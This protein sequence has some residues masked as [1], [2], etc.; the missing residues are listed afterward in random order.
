MAA[1]TLWRCGSG[2]TLPRLLMVT[3]SFPGQFRQA[4]GQDP[5]RPEAQDEEQ[6]D[7]DDDLA[8]GG[9]LHGAKIG[10]PAGDEARRFLEEDDENGAEQG[11]VIVSRPAGA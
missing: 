8:Q 1:A 4:L 2:S 9:D 6:R 11:A 10:N 5:L 3:P 7:A